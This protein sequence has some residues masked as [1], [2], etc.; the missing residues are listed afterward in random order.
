[1]SE[2]EL[3]GAILF[4]GKGECVA[5]HTGPALNSMTFYSYC[6]K[7]LEG[8][9]VIGGVDDAT[10]R[11][12][13]GFTGNP[14]DDYKFKTPQLY[15]LYDARFFGH[16]ATFHSV[17]DVI[18]YKNRALPQDDGIPESQ[19]AEEFRPLGLTETE[20]DELAAFVESALHDPELMRYQP[21]S[22]PSGECV[23]DNDG[24]S[25]IDLGCE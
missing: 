25:R 4:F 13:G 7:D 14:A 18:K 3:R 5:C 12:R 22:V 24:P 8:P 19:I 11:G 20:M 17:R 2:F 6:M 23:I 9:G 21:D 15:N 10:R 16:G 1:M